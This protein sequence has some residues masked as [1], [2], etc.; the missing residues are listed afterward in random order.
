VSH[1]C[2]DIAGP[3]R[4]AGGVHSE[5]SGNEVEGEPFFIVYQRQ[6]GAFKRGDLLLAIHLGDEEGYLWHG[7]CPLSQTEKAL[8]GPEEQG[9]AHPGAA[10]AG[11]NAIQGK[12]KTLILKFIIICLESK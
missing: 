5:F 4:N 12:G 6:E 1:G 9:D 3:D 7:E 10:G 2:D 11:S 8:W